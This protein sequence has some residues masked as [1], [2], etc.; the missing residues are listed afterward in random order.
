[1]KT[2]A[3][4]LILMIAS[5]L[6]IAAPVPAD[7]V[8]DRKHQIKAAFIYNFIKFIDWPEEKISADSKSITIGIVGNNGFLKAFDPIKRKKI[9]GKNVVIKPFKEFRKK[10]NSRWKKEIAALKKCH[11]LFICA[12]VH[13]KAETPDELLK[14][15][16]DSG[17]LTIGEMPE[18][19]EKGGVINFI[20][21]KQK[22]RFEINA[23]VADRNG[24]KI[25]SQLLKLA[26]RVIK[27]KQDKEAKD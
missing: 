5:L 17:V 12:Y 13:E 16:K 3:Y 18:F 7:S 9:M 21:E 6:A 2:K 27:N 19:L 14:A 25:R 22:V 24:L 8:K 4:I 10:N 20:M 15:M 23:A 1:M 26:K 11:V